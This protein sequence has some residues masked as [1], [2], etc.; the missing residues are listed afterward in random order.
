[1]DAATGFAMLVAV[2]A[3]AAF[4][5][6]RLRAQPLA[7]M[8]VVG[9]FATPFVVGGDADAQMVLFTYVALLVGAI[10]YLAHRRDWPALTLASFLLT[11]LTVSVWYLRFYEPGAWLRTEL[12]L[13]LYAALFLSVLYRSRESTRPFAGATRWALATTPL[14]YHAASLSILGDH[15]LAFLVYLIA[16]TGAGVA[17]AARAGAMWA[18]VGLWALVAWP[19]LGWTGADQDGSWLAPALVTWVAVASLHAAAQI[20]LLRRA[21]GPLHAADVV[22]VPVNG[23]G[24]AFGLQALLQPH[25]PAATGLVTAFLAVAWWAV[26]AGVRRIDPGAA[27]HVLALAA[28]L[29]VA[30]IGLQLD[31][32]V[33]GPG[34]RGPGGGPGLGGH[35]PSGVRGSAPPGPVCSGWRRCWRWGRMAAPVPAAHAVIL[36]RRALLGLFVVGV[37]ALVAWLH[38][39]EADRDI[40]HRGPALAAAV[41][42]ANALLLVTLS[43]EI[44]AFWELR[45]GHR[46]QRGARHAD[47]AVGDLGRLRRRPD[48]GGHPAALR[49]RPLPR[50]RG[51]RRHRPQGV[52]RRLLAA[53]FGLPHRQQRGAGAAAPG[54]VVPLS[55]A[56]RRAE[57]GPYGFACRAGR[58][59]AGTFGHRHRVEAVR[60]VSRQPPAE[61][62]ELEPL[63]SG[64][65]CL[66]RRLP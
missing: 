27:M 45:Q 64:R 18:R 29:A 59:D 56:E 46:R 40:P 54:R 63:S 15:W 60:T 12:F 21:G 61:P 42:G 30:A 47:D 20:E 43:M 38:R 13:T 14:W 58:A 11:G 19:L 4:Q 5:A 37:L 32:L 28:T 17:V 66:D 3:F 24:L 8:A 16:L 39:R 26:A 49:A 65:A 22:L 31:G 52:P 2:T 9:G 41:V 50:H 34:V 35:P 10:V 36:N 55:A 48:R 33:G 57:R 1:M 7:M 25:F 62:S 6:D 53:R 23:L 51:L 44:R